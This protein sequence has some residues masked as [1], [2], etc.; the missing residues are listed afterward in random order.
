MRAGGDC[1]PQPMCRNPDGTTINPLTTPGSQYPVYG[2][3]PGGFTGF[4]PG[5]TQPYNTGSSFSNHSSTYCRKNLWTDLII[6]IQVNLSEVLCIKIQ[7]NLSSKIK[8]N[9][10]LTWM[11]P[12]IDKSYIIATQSTFPLVQWWGSHAWKT[13]LII[14]VLEMSYLTEIICCCRYIMYIYAYWLYYIIPPTYF[15]T[16][17]NMTNLDVLHEIVP[18]TIKSV[19]CI[20]FLY[21]SSDVCIYKGSIY[22]QGETWEDGCDFKCTCVD[23]TRGMYQCTAR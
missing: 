9:V 13:I 23:E 3:Y 12:R 1:C 22:R 17:S 5:Y 4:R 21:F 14:Q 20:S 10:I 15:L 8:K 18:V 11:E 7:S 19:L 6:L 2:T 16:L